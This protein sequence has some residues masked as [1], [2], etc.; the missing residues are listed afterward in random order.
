MPHLEPKLG[1]HRRSPWLWLITF[2]GVIVPSR[3]RAE[4]RQE[5]KAELQYRE[6][7][8]AEWDD[9]MNSTGAAKLICSGTARA[10]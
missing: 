7:L 4:W 5:W 6:A 1:Q 2:I 3:L 9:G 8:L 10:L